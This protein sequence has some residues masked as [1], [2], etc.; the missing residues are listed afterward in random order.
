M[1][2]VLPP[3]HDG[4]HGSRVWRGK[5]PVEQE[6]P[7]FGN[8]PHGSQQGVTPCTPH[9]ARRALGTREK[10]SW[11]GFYRRGTTGATAR[12]S[13]VATCQL[14]RKD[15]HSAMGLMAR[16]KRS[17]WIED[18]AGFFC[19]KNIQAVLKYP[20]RCYWCMDSANRKK[21][22]CFPALR[23][24]LSR[25][26]AS[27]APPFESAQRRLRGSRA[28]IGSGGKKARPF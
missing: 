16:I 12:R 14:D 3:W 23:N 26:G 15:R 27:Q 7:P 4:C 2:G 5:P 18:H 6:R 21:Q 24:H 25:I 9:R 11:P 28:A 22:T 8:G 19:C 10:A 13:G 20:K 1:A 17:A